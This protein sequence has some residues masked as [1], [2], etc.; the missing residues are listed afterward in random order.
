MAKRNRGPTQP[1]WRPDFRDPELLPDIKVVRTDFF[2]TVLSVSLVIILYAVLFHRE[3][4]VRALSEGTQT[5]EAKVS[6]HQQKNREN[7]RLSQEFM[8]LSRSIGEVQQ[9]LV[10]PVPVTDLMLLISELRPS[11]IRFTT[12]SYTTRVETVGR[13]RRP[14]YSIQV[15]GQVRGSAFEVPGI[16]NDF[17]ESLEAAPQVREHLRS[18]DIRSLARD[19]N[20][21]HF[22]LSMSIELNPHPEK[23]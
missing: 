15:N 20:Q 23:Q 9:F 10:I 2:L 8:N 16:V 17:K 12:F 13:D 18:A 14:V 3:Y 22:T 11:A 19:P 5:L 21:G 6:D 1:P 4:T 7:V